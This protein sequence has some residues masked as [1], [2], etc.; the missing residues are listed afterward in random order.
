MKAVS[1]TVL[2]GAAILA[3]GAGTLAMAAA[4]DRHVL[5]VR[6]PDGTVEQIRYSGD[7]A[8]TVRFEADRPA[9]ALFAPVLDADPLFARLDQVSA[10][11]DR[12]AAAMLAGF[13][14][15]A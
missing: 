11:M 3:L 10:E 7:V 6:L 4:R 9:A 5:N 14:D 2:A 13:D 15:L 8:P 12:E 1:R